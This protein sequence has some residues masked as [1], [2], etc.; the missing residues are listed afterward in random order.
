[1]IIQL[2]TK[3]MRKLMQTLCRSSTEADADEHIEISMPRIVR[4]ELLELLRI[5]CER[6]RKP[7]MDA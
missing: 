7:D 2:I 3:R 6:G 1:M 4:N 5:L